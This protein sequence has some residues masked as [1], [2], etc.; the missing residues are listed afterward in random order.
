MYQKLIF[1]IFTLLVSATF[2]QTPRNYAANSVLKEGD[3]Y[4][5][6]ILQE[7][8]YRLDA[9]YFQAIGIEPASINPATIQIFG[10]GAGVVPQANADFR[11]DD[12]YEN[13]IFVSS[14]GNT[15]GQNDYVLFYGAS[16]HN[17]TFNPTNQ[18]FAHQQNVY[19]DSNFYFLKVGQNV[20][21]RIET[22][23]Q[24]AA[25]YYPA[26]LKN[27][28]FHEVEAYNKG[29]SGRFWVGEYF[30]NILERTISLY[31]P[32]VKAGS[33]MEISVQ[34]ATKTAV[35]GVQFLV[36]A[37]N[38]I[39]YRLQGFGTNGAED[40]YR[41]KK[42]TFNVNS[43]AIEGDSLRLKITFD[44]GSSLGAEGWLDWIVVNYEQNASMNGQEL[45]YFSLTE[46]IGSGKVAGLGI[47]GLD[48]SYRLWD[49]SETANPIAIVPQNSQ[50]SVGADN[51]RRFVAFKGGFKTPVAAQKIVPQDLHALPLADYLMI[52]NPLFLTEAERLAAFH[53]NT[54]NHSVHIVTPAQIY[55]EFS[56]GKQDVSGIRD[57]IKMFHDR[58]EGEFPK[59]VLLFGDGSYD[60]K[61]IQVPTSKNLI[62]TYQSRQFTYTISAYTS[63]DFFVMLSDDEGFWA[64]S[65]DGRV[66]KGS[67]DA[68]IGRFPVETVEEAKHVVDKVI[69]YA[70]NTSDFGQ[71]KNKV[72]L[73]ADY[74]EGDG[75]NAPSHMRQADGYTSIINSH[76]PAINI[77]KIY[78]DNYNA[79]VTGSKK[80]YPEAK[81]DLLRKLDEGA[82]IINWT[83]HGGPEGWAAADI[84]NNTDIQNTHNGARL[85]AIITATCDFG[86]YDN[87]EKRTGA[88]LFFIQPDGG[89]IA[90]FTTVRKV[91]GDPNEALNRAIYNHALSFDSLLRRFLTIGE[92]MQRTK[93]DMY[94]SSGLLNENSR[95]FSLYADPG[96]TLAYP[97]LRANLTH[98]NNKT[99]IMNEPDTIQSLTEVEIKGKI[100]D[101]NGRFISDY[102]G[103]MEITIYD[104]PNLFVTKQEQFRFYWQKNRLFNG[105]VTIKEGLFTCKFVVPIDI[106]YDEGFGK[107]SLYFH[108]DE[109]DGV[110][111]FDKLALDGTVTA[112]NDNDGPDVKLYINDENWVNGGK[113][114]SNPDL[115]AVVTD[116]SGI[117][118][119]G[120]GIGHEITAYLND[121]P[122]N[123]IVLNEYYKAE[124]DNYQKGTVRYQ[125]RDLPVGKYTAN[126]RVWDVANNS[127]EATTDFIVADN[128]VM[129]L[130]EIFNY[131]NPFQERTAFCV[132]HNLEAE[133][134]LLE[135]S[136]YNLS[137]QL[138][139]KLSTAFYAEGNY[140]RDLTWDGVDENGNPVGAG[141]YMYSVV[142]QS[143]ASGKSVSAFKKM[144]LLK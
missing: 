22:M 54:L 93:N 59:Y 21:K 137:G 26:S 13:P 131:P 32:N 110:G 82:L 7:G 96:I 24:M 73:V 95:N 70:T 124:K 69:K 52:V 130:T 18:Q 49:I 107:I 128:A 38:G 68:A 37:K 29:N 16:P 117:N 53:R 89:A 35:S 5:I 12:V 92:I 135:V 67:L 118:I 140:N 123:S 51:V 3:T 105:K 138:L 129:A 11:Y 76:N 8:I 104:K 87:P 75:A 136:I 127:G 65:V 64:E 60:Y 23:P 15:F 20:G 80:T 2:A 10:N 41:L 88:E 17:A 72:V 58:S 63:D 126:I 74:Y 47:S 116:K 98:I 61:G 144:I 94:Q 81:A 46:G 133:D 86:R 14:Q 100:E 120:T 115:Y 125:L 1:S 101:T 27:S 90:L 119:T 108:N 122:S 109:I 139:K 25:N 113:T 99:L 42:A 56:G 62:P 143:K 48:N 79:E 6:A 111:Y 78:F 55:N 102:A 134:L 112:N 9:A 66:D 19:S 121:D 141:A 31:V 114:S 43:A 39:T 44:K 91:Y 33:S 57:F 77:D 132:G 45:L 34:A 106:S 36:A 30:N 4:K 142:L 50:F 97:K 84:L 40:I 85:P 103:E 71:W 28:D 83:G